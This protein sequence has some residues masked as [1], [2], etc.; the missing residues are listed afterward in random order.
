[1]PG[2][3]I[4][5]I[6][7]V[8]RAAPCLFLPAS[9]PGCA[10]ERPVEHSYQGLSEDSRAGCRSRKAIAEPWL[11]VF[12]KLAF[13]YGWRRAQLLGLRVRQVN[14]ALGTIPLDT[15]TTKNGDR[16]FL[17]GGYLCPGGTD[18]PHNSG[19]FFLPSP[20]AH[21]ESPAWS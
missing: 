14:L 15:G 9:E 11:R 12:L 2:L 18:A 1:M 8:L 5:G 16:E 13:T 3:T 7:S 20:A 21:S 6:A 4:P 17:R 19:L 10:S